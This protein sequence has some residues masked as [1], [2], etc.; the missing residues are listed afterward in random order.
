MNLNQFLK[1]SNYDMIHA[2]MPTEY[3]SKRE[4]QEELYE[5]YRNFYGSIKRRI[6]GLFS[7]NIFKRRRYRYL[8]SQGILKT[9][10][11]LF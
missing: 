4:V 5:C 3:L 11:D 8:A 9:L 2:I 10:R 7:P 1:K 6:T